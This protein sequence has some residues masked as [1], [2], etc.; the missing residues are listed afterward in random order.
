MNRFA[1]LGDRH[2]CNQV[3]VQLLLQLSQRQVCCGVKAH[4]DACTSHR[5]AER[6][7]M[8]ILARPGCN[9][10]DSA[11]MLGF[12]MSP[13]LGG[14]CVNVVVRCNLGSDACLRC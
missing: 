5:T 10:L 3:D 4:M 1:C 8:Q 11:P 9:F 7:T 2:L 6:P 12:R 14:V 13:R